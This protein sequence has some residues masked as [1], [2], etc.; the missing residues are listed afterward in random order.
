MK[1]ELPLLFKTNW[2]W[3]PIRIVCRVDKYAKLACI[4]SSF[5]FKQTVIISHLSINKISSS[6]S[7]NFLLFSTQKSPIIKKYSVTF[8]WNEIF[9]LIKCR[10]SPSFCKN[11]DLIP[12]RNYTLITE[13]L[14]KKTS[15]SIIELFEKWWNF[16][17]ISVSPIDSA[18]NFTEKTS[19]T[20]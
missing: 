5:M 15:F 14:F 8:Y 4:D 18:W 13:R 6:K 9:F 2:R 1:F 20:F 17:E 3:S 16:V 10:I 19:Y 11:F 12:L 7:W